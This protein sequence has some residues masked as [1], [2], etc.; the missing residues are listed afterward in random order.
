MEEVKKEEIGR[1]SHYYAK[2]GVAVV[3]LTGGLK[4]GDEVLIEGGDSKV[5]Q[6]VESM[7][8]EH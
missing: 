3:D 5:R 1:V 4:V 8:I 7:Q 2:I 6:K